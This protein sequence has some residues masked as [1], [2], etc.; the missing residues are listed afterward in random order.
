MEK[1]LRLDNKKL[2]TVNFQIWHESIGHGLFWSDNTPK[3]LE[4]RLELMTQ[5]RYIS[6]ATSGT[7]AV[8]QTE[9]VI[10][11]I[12]GRPVRFSVVWL[13]IREG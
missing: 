4:E 3:I 8:K 13:D 2:Y 11:K 7:D 5:Y 6:L 1:Q 10:D 9:N 12:W